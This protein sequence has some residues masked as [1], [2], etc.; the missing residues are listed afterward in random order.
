LASNALPTLQPA[1]LKCLSPGLTLW[2]TYDGAE[3]AIDLSGVPDGEGQVFVLRTGGAWRMSVSAA[4]IQ[5]RRVAR[6]QG[7]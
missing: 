5:L 3:V 6:A 1:R 2:G 4:Q 7:A